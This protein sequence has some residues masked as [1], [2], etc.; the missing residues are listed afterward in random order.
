MLISFNLNVVCLEGLY[1][2]LPTIEQLEFFIIK[3]IKDVF[4]LIRGPGLTHYGIIFSE[5]KLTLA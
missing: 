2:I 3:I 1:P 5:K 4:T